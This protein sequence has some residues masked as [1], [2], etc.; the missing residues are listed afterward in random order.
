METSLSSGDI[1]EIVV[2]QRDSRLLRQRGALSCS[3]TRE[4]PLFTAEFCLRDIAE[5]SR[6]A[7]S[8][9][10]AVSSPAV[11]KHPAFLKTRDEAAA[12]RQPRYSQE[13]V[14]IR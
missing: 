12:E 7:S 9:V 2:R 4:Q 6:G 14:Q 10:H 13:L 1:A 5:V 11:M 8:Q 3:L